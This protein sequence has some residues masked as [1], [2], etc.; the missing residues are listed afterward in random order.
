M[1]I[2]S[3][4]RESRNQ[5]LIDSFMVK[6]APTLTPTTRDDY[7]Q[8][9]NHMSDQIDFG[10]EENVII[11]WLSTIENPNTR[12]NKAFAL[13]R[14]RKC[15]ALPTDLLAAYR[16]ELRKEIRMHRK[17]HAK[18][19]L[20]SLITYDELLGKLDQLKG[21]PY[22]MNYL[23]V[24]HGLRN[25]DINLRFA[26]RLA[27]G[28]TM[29][30]PTENVILCNLKAKNPVATLNI[31]DYKTA[32]KYGP[33][34]IVIKDARFIHELKSLNLKGGSYVFAQR[35][36]TKPTLNHMNV[37]AIKDS[38]NNYGEGR[39]AKILVKHLIDTKQ[40]DRV[41]Q[42]SAQR[43]TSLATLYTTYNVWDN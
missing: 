17:E 29:P 36:G 32:K 24:H 4:D 42:L 3:D 18:A 16:E 21:K 15:N 23:Y 26:T 11:D 12:T 8:K 7:I 28:S 9:L 13:I 40:F 6:V 39:I 22:I 34:T 20:Q 5:D 2:S 14:C 19:N 30:Y 41:D 38:I 10:A 37:R 27:P 33:K 35:N 25:K 31:V 1:M 43:G